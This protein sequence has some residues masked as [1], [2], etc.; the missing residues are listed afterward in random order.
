MEIE[1]I[2][3]AFTVCKVT[4]LSAVDCGA[5]YCFTARTDEECSVV[6]RTEDVPRD[7]VAREDGWS[8][9]RVTGTLDFSLIGILSKITGALAAADVSVFAVSTFNTDYFLV[10]QAQ[11]ASACIA[12]QSAGYTVRR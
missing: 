11:E 3:G 8:M 4:E 7:T 12:L 10:R 6:C 2:D 1:R 9:F 5:A